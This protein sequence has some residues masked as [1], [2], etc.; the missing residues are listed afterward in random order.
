M[1]MRVSSASRVSTA[2]S[3]VVA[4]SASATAE[5]SSDSCALA[6]PAALVQGLR[7]HALELGRRGGHEPL[8]VGEALWVGQRADCGVHL[9]V[10]EHQAFRVIVGRS[11]PIT[12]PTR[13]PPT[14]AEM[15]ASS[16]VSER[17][18]STAAI[19]YTPSRSFSRSLPRR[20]CQP[21]VH[22]PGHEHAERRAVARRIT[23]HRGGFG[24]QRRGLEQHGQTRA[25]G[26]GKDEG[27]HH[28]DGAEAALEQRPEDADGHEC[29]KRI[30]ELVAV[31]ERR[32]EPAPDVVVGG[33]RH[34]Q[35][36]DVPQR[37][38]RGN[39][40]ADHA[41]DDQPERRVGPR[42]RRDAGNLL[43]AQPR[44]LALA[45][46]PL[47]LRLA[48]RRSS[49]GARL[50][51]RVPAVRALGDVRG[52]L[53]AAVLADD[54]QVRLPTGHLRVPGAACAL[55]PAVAG[56][57]RGLRHGRVDDL[58][59]D[60]AQVV[61]GLV[62]DLAAGRRRCRARADPSMPSSSSSEPRSCACSRRRSRGAAR[63]PWPA[64]ARGR[65]GRR[66]RPRARGARPATCSR[67]A[68]RT[69]SR[70]S[71]LPASKCS[72]SSLTIAWTSAASASVCST[73]VWASIARIST[74]PKFGCGRTS[75][76]R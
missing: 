51:S 35:L 65:A 6:E 11:S 5:R 47:R 69:G 46:A 21:V 40:H 67:R 38:P 70:A 48:A 45:L 66:A 43:G 30:S 72:A 24:Q 75:Y 10:R 36:A 60:L 16:V 42:V 22:E 49:F 54:E 73:R 76:Q 50:R 7:Q 12:A 59:H 23:G 55:G 9:L 33:G 74:V 18:T 1:P 13:A 64:P 71:C 68:S 58:A 17:S 15:F 26:A 62:D 28:R 44:Q 56:G 3:P 20:C 29:D 52:H 14:A 63:A 37:I 61:V 27:G 53:R 34:D 4:S 57:L 39:Q 31:Q 2:A 8:R 19:T 32:E 41:D 25:G